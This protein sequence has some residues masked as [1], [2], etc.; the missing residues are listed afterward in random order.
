MR[1]GFVGTGT[2]GRPIAEYLIGAGHRLT[3]HDLG[4][5][6][7]DRLATDIVAAVRAAGGRL[8][9]TGME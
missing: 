8:V 4:R 3:V 1:V 9:P 6:D 5:V 2:M 7:T